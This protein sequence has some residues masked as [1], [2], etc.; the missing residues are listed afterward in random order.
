MIYEESCVGCY[1]F[2]MENINA[3]I[4]FIIIKLIRNVAGTFRII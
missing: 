2:M 3:Y 1:D 4:F